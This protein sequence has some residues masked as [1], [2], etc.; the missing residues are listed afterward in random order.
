MKYLQPDEQFWA[1]YRRR[2]RDLDETMARRERRREKLD[3]K[4]AR[5]IKLGKRKPR[6][7]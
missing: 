7:A 4:F 5:S 3:Q 1:E 6:A 2:L